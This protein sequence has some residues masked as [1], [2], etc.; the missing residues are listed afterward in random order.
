MKATSTRVV[1]RQHS[2]P[3][4]T[5]F[6][7]KCIICQSVYLKMFEFLSTDDNNNNAWAMIIFL[8]IFMFW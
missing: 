8:L 4:A 7:F 2:L 1:R 3:A 6:K 5:K